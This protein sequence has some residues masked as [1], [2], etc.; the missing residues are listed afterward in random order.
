MTVNALS[1]IENTS[2]QL[3]CMVSLEPMD[4]AVS[5]WPCLHSINEDSAIERYGEIVDEKCSN[6]GIAC[7]LCPKIVVSY[8]RNHLISSL[9]NEIQGLQKVINEEHI[10]HEKLK[11]NLHVIEKKLSDSKTGDSKNIH[12]NVALPETIYQRKR[13]KSKLSEEKLED[14]R[15]EHRNNVRVSHSVN[16]EFLVCVAGC[17]GW[18]GEATEL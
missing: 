2:R 9:T 1:L 11:E 4:H 14:Y 12:V 18:D 16:S 5:L 3:E 15:I 17:F 6:V 10:E 7:I 13:A 8:A